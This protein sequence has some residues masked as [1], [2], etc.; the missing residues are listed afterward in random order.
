MHVLII[1]DEPLTALVLQLLS[2][3]SGATSIDVANS[4][5]SAISAAEARRPDII[6]ADLTLRD[7]S[8]PAAVRSIRAGIGPVPVIYVTATPRD[9]E[10]LEP[11]DRLL[12]K[13]LNEGAFMRTLRAVQATLR[14]RA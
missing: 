7:G 11:N 3:D 1:E 6:T 2:Q 10:D 5:A 8:G 9:C 12:G 14:P 13:P 4:E